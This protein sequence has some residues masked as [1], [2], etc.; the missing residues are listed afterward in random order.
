MDI[1]QTVIA[2]ALRLARATVAVNLLAVLTCSVSAAAGETSAL[3]ARISTLRSELLAGR[4]ATEI[5]TA[6]CAALGFAVPATIRAERIRGADKLAD[7]RTR[8]PLAVTAGD[9]V[10]YRHVRLSC[11]THILSE[12]DNWYVPDRLTAAMNR[13]LTETDTPFGAVVRPLGFHRKTLEAV[14]LP[15][16]SPAVLRV[17]ALLITRTGLP[18]SLVAE[19]YSRVLVA[20]KRAVLGPARK[21]RRRV[22]RKYLKYIEK[23]SNRAPDRRGRAGWGT[24]IRT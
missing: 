22:K 6:H 5:L 17:R 23:M 8:K 18:F 14:T 2:R 10:L 4:S 24:R 16:H 19:D 13:T 15:R 1:L 12:A 11:G 20:A 3:A 7:A 9:R 21:V